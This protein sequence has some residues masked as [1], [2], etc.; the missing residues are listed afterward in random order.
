MKRIL[1]TGA[2]GCIGRHALPRLVAGGWDVH[3]LSSGRATPEVAGVTLHVS[4][5][6]PPG[7]GARAIASIRPEALLHL[8]W[9]VAPG[10]WAVAPANLDWVPASLELVRAFADAGGQRLVGAGSG[11]EYDWNYG[12][13]SERR[14]PCQ[15]HT[16]YG[17]C[18][19]ALHLM[20]EDFAARAG[21][22]AAWARIF[23]LYGPF[24]HPDR[25]VAFVIRSLIKGARAPCSH[26]MQV[27]DYLFADDVAA[28]LVAL[29]DRP[30]VRGAI[31]VASGQPI[32]LRSLAGR[33]GDLLGKR[34]LIDF[35]AIPAA[36]TDMPLV[37]ADVTRLTSE[38]GWR[39]AFDLDSGLGRTI[40]WWTREAA[41]S[42][43]VV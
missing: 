20:V 18:K 40:E 5:L 26:G 22:S 29:V 33:A 16:L 2:T 38:L 12:Y 39:P 30:D 4:V 31:N 36:A 43:A 42:P 8:A 11:L 21:L 24:E 14:T 17:T 10:R 7:A 19:H 37:V 41:A 25:L 3:A 23:F 32:T 27:R 6:L 1:V 15:P 35:G 34:E 28:A 13:C 9:F